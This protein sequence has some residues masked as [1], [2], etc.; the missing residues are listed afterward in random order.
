MADA[1]FE[2]GGETGLNLKAYAPEDVQVIAA[3][4][5]DAVLTAAD[6]IW[7]PKE[8]RLVFLV[9]RF[10][11]EDAARAEARGRGYERVRSLLVIDGVLHV[12]SQGVDKGDGDEVL[13]V[14]SLDWTPGEDAAGS[15][16][17]LLAGDGAVRADVECLDLTLKDV[18]RPY[19]AP[20]G[21]LPKHPD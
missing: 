14:L 12:A 15:V 20:S 8:R 10:R 2:E 5:Q 3:L 13:S 6:M 16:T 11:W 21:H 19:L 1:T 4:V 17:V 18:T 9:N 7:R